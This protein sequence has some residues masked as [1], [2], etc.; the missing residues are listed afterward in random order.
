VERGETTM[1]NL[2]VNQ[3]NGIRRSMES[4]T[5]EANKIFSMSTLLSLFGAL[6]LIIFS[7]ILIG[8]FFETN[9]SG[10]STE[11]SVIKRDINITR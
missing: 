9:A 3:N 4:S 7:S 2:A 11:S 8:G 5:G 10:A 6:L 1:T